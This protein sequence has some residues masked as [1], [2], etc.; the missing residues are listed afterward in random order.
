MAPQPVHQHWQEC[1]H[2]LIVYYWPMEALR[3]VL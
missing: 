2:L 1:F 3:L